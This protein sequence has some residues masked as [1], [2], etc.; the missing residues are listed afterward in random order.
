MRNLGK[1]YFLE[2]YHYIE[3]FHIGIFIFYFWLRMFFLKSML[4]ENYVHKVDGHNQIDV[5]KMEYDNAT[6]WK[7]AYFSILNCFL[8]ASVGLKC[9]SYMRI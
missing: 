7:I 8:Y 1:E 2:F 4:P 3:I 5:L 6:Y 9:M